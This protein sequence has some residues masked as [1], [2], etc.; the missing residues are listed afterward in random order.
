MENWGKQIWVTKHE[1]EDMW[2]Q[3]ISFIKFALKNWSTEIV[4]SNKKKLPL[5]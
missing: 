4:A 2:L 1:V 5:H 3:V